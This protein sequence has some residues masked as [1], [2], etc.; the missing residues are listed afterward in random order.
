MEEKHMEAA[1]AA[2]NRILEKGETCGSRT[3]EREKYNKC[4]GFELGVP[5]K[6]Q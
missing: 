6:R 2:R 4:G 1:R 5:G 3:K